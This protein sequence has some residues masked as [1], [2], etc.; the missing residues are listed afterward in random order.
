MIDWLWG[1][2]GGMLFGLLLG[3]IFALV[4]VLSVEKKYKISY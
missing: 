3:L 4:T 2:C 1:F